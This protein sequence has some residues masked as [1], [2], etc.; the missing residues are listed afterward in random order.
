MARQTEQREEAMRQRV[1]KRAQTFAR[2]RQQQEQEYED[3]LQGNGNWMGMSSAAMKALQEADEV[4]NAIAQADKKLASMGVMLLLSV[5]LASGQTIFVIADTNQLKLIPSH[6]KVLA[7]TNL[8]VNQTYTEVLTNW[9]MVGPPIDIKSNKV[10]VAR[11]IFQVS[12]LLT[13]TYKIYDE[14]NVVLLSRSDGP[15]LEARNYDIPPPLP[16][17]PVVMQLRQQR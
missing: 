11:R 6:I 3:H 13:N 15:Q 4:G 7:M 10:V 16:T 8:S 9:T 12:N 5:M 14:T 1:Q 17:L 2:R